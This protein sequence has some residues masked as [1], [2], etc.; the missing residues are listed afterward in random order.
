M[1]AQRVVRYRV[2]LGRAC[3]ARALHP[4]PR[5]PEQ[6]G[7]HVLGALDQD[8]ELP[9]DRGARVRDLL[10]SLLCERLL[11]RLVSRHLLLDDGRSLCTSIERSIDCSLVQS[12]ERESAIEHDI[13][14]YLT[15]R[16][17]VRVCRP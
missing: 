2:H 15:E 4:A 10:C 17:D 7:A 14:R 1:G 8:R 6:D 11:D 3:D 16:V 9:P 12:R 13:D 5:P